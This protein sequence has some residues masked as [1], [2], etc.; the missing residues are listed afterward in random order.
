MC[1]KKY[2]YEAVDELD[3]NHRENDDP[4]DSTTDGKMYEKTGSLHP[5]KTFELYLLKL[6]SE[7]N[8]LY[9]RPKQAIAATADN[10][11]YRKVPVGKNTIGNCRKDI[12]RHKTQIT[13]YE[14]Q[15]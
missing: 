1:T 7:L 11:W 8:V 3:K 15:P 6:H 14:Q 10:C 5:V 9:K 4:Q 2:V 12:S 13:A